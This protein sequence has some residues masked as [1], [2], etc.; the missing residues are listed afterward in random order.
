MAACGGPLGAVRARSANHCE[1]LGG[2][3]EAKPSLPFP[4]LPFLSLPFGVISILPFA[5]RV[6]CGLVGAVLTLA[7][8][9]T[10]AV[11]KDV[12]R[13]PEEGA[14]SWAQSFSWCLG[15]TPFRSEVLRF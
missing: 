9:V 13:G 12:T 15:C 7:G 8:P 1:C 3:T 2:A 11:T 10:R 6:G 5:V 4:S 14:N